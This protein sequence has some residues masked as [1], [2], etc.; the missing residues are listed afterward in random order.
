VGKRKLII[1]DWGNTLCNTSAAY[2]KISDKIPAIFAQHGIAISPE[3]YARLS[4]KV[5]NDLRREL[6]GD[7]A[8]HALGM[9]EARIAR[10]LGK[11]ITTMAAQEIDSEIHCLFLKNCTAIDGAEHF[12]RK[13]K[14]AGAKLILISNSN[15]NKLYSEIRAL[16]FAKYFCKIICSEECGHEKSDLVPYKM[17]LEAALKNGWIAS[18]SDVLVIGDREEE[19]GAA[20]KLGLQ[21]RI[22]GKDA[23]HAFGELEAEL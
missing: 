18:N 21:V 4:S 9:H 17:A 1:L 7:V 2:A 6:K 5:R 15:Q 10:E 20:R 13:A 3:D 14:S 16:G 8:R 11:T 23:P 12:L 22:I 19:D